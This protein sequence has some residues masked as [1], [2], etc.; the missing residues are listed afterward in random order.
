MREILFD[1]ERQEKDDPKALMDAMQRVV[2][3]LRVTLHETACIRRHA[4]DALR[5][6]TMALTRLRRSQ[7][8]PLASRRTH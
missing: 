1:Q 3:E 6:T 7:G 4:K 2:D 8:R 5:T